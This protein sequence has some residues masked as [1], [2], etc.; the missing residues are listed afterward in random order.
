[1][2]SFLQDL[3]FGFRQLLGKP[4]FTAIAI[5]SLA[6]GIGANTAIFSLVDAVLLRPLPF[7]DPDRLVMVWEDAA[8]IGFPR[9]TP[10]PA[11][12]ADW[13]AQNQVFEDMA[14]LDWRAYNMTDEGEPEKVGA[15]AVT[16]NF[17]PLLGV[18]PELGRVFNAE[19]DKPD[20][21]KVALISYGLWQR[22][23]GGNPALIGKEILL[24]EQKHTV[25]G[26]MP[27]G[28][29][30]MANETGLW[31]PMAFSRE[32]LAR[33]GNHYLTVVARMKP[34]VSLRQAHADIAA[35]TQRINRDNPESWSGFDLG[36]VVISLRE[37]LAGDVRPALIVLLVAVGF[38]LLIACAN[39]ANL[40]LSRGAARYREVAVRA[41][42]GAGR[43]RIMRQLLTESVLLA[44]AGGVS[45]LLF[46]WLSFSFLKQIIP[47]GMALNAVVRID[48]R[49]FGFTL[50]LS[51]LTGIVFGLAPALQA[52]KVDLNEALKQGGG[53]AG[54]GAGHRRLRSALVVIEVALALVLL[55]GAGLLIQ[56]FLRLRALDIGVNPENVL[57]LRTALPGNKYGELPKRTA[58]YQQVL[59]RMRALPGVVSAGY[60]T[61]TPLT[62]KG[63]TN[64]FLVEGR[65][66]A[67]GQD[68]Q[69]RQ[70][71]TGYMET[72]GVKLLQG[73]FFD[74]HD[75]A[76]AQPVAIINETMAR[77][78]WPGENAM[79]KR[80]RLG[81]NNSQNSWVTVVGV[82]GD[83][84]EMG[85]EAPAKAEMFF[86]YR[87][88]PQMLWNMPRD[89]AVRTTGDPMSVAAAARQ[90]VWSVDPSQP[91]SN[92]RTM[93][94]ILAEEVAQRRIG[95]T[96]L[97]AFAALA[98]ALAS[99]GIYGVL[100]YSVSQR[101]QEIGVRMAL[102]AGRKE[103]L[104]LVLADG[105]L[106]AVAGVAIGLGVSFALTR[107]MAGLLFGVSASDPLTLGGV[108]LLLLAVALTAC[109]I[110]ARRATK[111][112]PMAAL[113]AE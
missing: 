109:F 100:S 52:A 97:A 93:D 75:G 63:G 45:G 105:M 5:L 13:R 24:D 44:V 106:L 74:D 12:Y 55:A 91:V 84:K 41:A 88:L 18:K 49:V 90:A 3:R 15:Q 34:G 113:R 85:L 71:S 4:G 82:I 35:I 58:F 14:A 32:T 10:A 68:A 29:Q 30:F 56:A 70:V 110:P 69:S 79:G 72:M 21:N 31:V 46:A 60:T 2:E 94:E 66:Q 104:R 47:N 51:L 11:N 38:V 59:E 42:L 16:A 92:I 86:P 53:R 27:P 1:M 64:S 111:V 25:I 101:T 9:N 23:F 61:A 89:L 28:F 78:F 8:K 83:I 87:Q 95:M 57:T 99:L 50:L 112:D 40:L 98:L 22:R 20:G 54:T 80:F 43:N 37:Q 39:I 108:T 19:E 103:V 7:Q 6:L 73:R 107:L 102:G 81:V 76:Q 48:A 62:W 26:V 33:R 17:F 65:D 77:Q 36:S 67:P 96:L